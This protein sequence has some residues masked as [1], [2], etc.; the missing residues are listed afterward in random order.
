MC[1]YMYIY[2]HMA[3]PA[4]AEQSQRPYCPKTH[5]Q[6][7]QYSFCVV[8]LHSFAAAVFGKYLVGLEPTRWTRSRFSARLTSCGSMQQG[9]VAKANTRSSLLYAGTMFS[10]KHRHAPTCVVLQM[11]KGGWMMMKHWLADCK[12]R[13]MPWPPGAGPPEEPLE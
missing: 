11:K 4:E 12:S 6:S 2:I 7:I 10:L 5:M 8:H 1:M 9:C 3:L 13:R